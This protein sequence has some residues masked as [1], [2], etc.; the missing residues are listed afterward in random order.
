MEED[1]VRKEVKLLAKKQLKG[2]WSSIIIAMLVV[3]IVI[4]G[5][6]IIIDI[7]DL[8]NSDNA[9][10]TVSLMTLLL[11]GA[12]ILG[13]HIYTLKF[14][15]GHAEFKDIMSGF[16]YYLKATGLYIMQAI[17]VCLGL[18]MLIIPGVIIGIKLSQATFILADDR[19]KGVIQCLKESW[20]M[21]SGKCGEYFIFELSFLGWIL[22]S[23]LT[24][25]VGFIFLFPYMYVS[26]GNYYERIKL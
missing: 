7:L 19:S 10:L 22:L 20:N 17:L 26:L 1:R 5:P 13:A 23:I 4:T 25:G 15:R 3:T 6:Q 16:K 2:R 11:D 9:N 24:V 21:M 14:I 12:V 18:V 8:N